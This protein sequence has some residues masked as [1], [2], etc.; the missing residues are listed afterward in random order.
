MLF[1]NILAISDNVVMGAY[2]GMPRR[3]Y[4]DEILGA[5]ALELRAKGLSYREIAGELGCSIFKV[6][7]LISSYESPRSRIR[8]VHELATRVEELSRKIRNLE[9]LASRLEATIKPRLST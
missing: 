7:Q 4:D 2:P 8:Q 3:R 9:S 1:D 6:H 5:G